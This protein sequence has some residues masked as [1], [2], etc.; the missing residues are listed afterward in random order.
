MAGSTPA[1]LLRWPAI[2]SRKARGARA[3][4]I[5]GFSRK[6]TTKALG[7]SQGLFS[8]PSLWTVDILISLR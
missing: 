2:E 1:G 8:F 3:Q 4:P 7:F 5:R 6:Q